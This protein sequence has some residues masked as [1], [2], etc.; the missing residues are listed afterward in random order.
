M[1]LTHVATTSTWDA[2]TGSVTP[3]MPTGT[4]VGDLVIVT[5]HSKYDDAIA[6]TPAGWTEIASAVSNTGRS[7]G[8]DNGN[9]RT[10][11]I[12]R[13]WQSGD[14]MPTISPT[15]NNVSAAKAST[16]RATS[17]T[18]DLAGAIV[19]D[20]TTGSPITLNSG[21]TLG[22][23]SG[24]ILHVDWVVNGDAP[25]LG[26]FSG[27]ATGATLSPSATTWLATGTTTLGTDLRFSSNSQTCTAGTATG[28]WIFTSTL[29]GTTTNAVGTGA[30]YRIREAAAA[31]SLTVDGSTQTQTAD[32][33]SLTQVHE[34]GALA[35]TQAQTAENVALGQTHILV[36]NA[37]TQAQTAENV[38]LG[39]VSGT[40]LVVQDA[41]HDM[42]TGPAALEVTLAVQD[43]TQGHS[44][45][46][47]SLT[48]VHSLTAQDAGQAQTSENPALTQTHILSVQP[49]AH[50]QAA[51]SPSLV[52]ALAVQDATHGHAVETVTLGSPSGLTVQDATQAVTSDAP[53][54][55]QIHALTVQG[56]TH[57]Q[58]SESVALGVDLAVQAATQA[59]TADAPALTQVHNLTADS[60]TH[61]HTAESVTLG[62]AGTLSAAGATQAHSADNVA[63]TQVHVLT[64]DSA[65]HAHVATT[66]AITQ[67]HVLAVNG[68]IHGHTAAA[69]TLTVLADDDGVPIDQPRFTLDDTASVLVLTYTNASL[70]IAAA[71]AALVLNDTTA[72]LALDEQPADLLVGV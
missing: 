14:S 50:A 54:L 71:T 72:R 13:V 60:A 1:S 21:S 51:D 27:S 8:V 59:Q 32:S 47:P 34:L 49:A 69:P 64:V 39:V 3:A 26:V 37:A 6:S 18:Y 33:P 4:T 58:T 24:D 62:S 55:T 35:A 31:T 7:T 2:S 9:T 43:A 41:H 20:D 70:S 19:A 15:P 53:T 22:I 65:T 29:G 52:V 68:A 10:K 30:M 40:D 45:A 28:N 46:T 44:S 61:G 11:S 23:T 66:V 48:Q 36:L 63:L 57:G 56:A 42:T 25:T 5:V 67:A 17:G 16:Y 38:T 12:Y